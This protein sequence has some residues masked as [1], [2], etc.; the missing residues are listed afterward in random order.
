MIPLPPST[1]IF[2]ACGATDSHSLVPQHASMEE[3]R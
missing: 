1:R 3:G 2:L